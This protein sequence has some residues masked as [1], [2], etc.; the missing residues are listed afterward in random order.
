[1][2]MPDVYGT[3]PSESISADA[4]PGC[5]SSYTRERFLYQVSKQLREIVASR[6][7]I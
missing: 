5:R 4:L 6:A 3:P 7:R 2:K 1:M